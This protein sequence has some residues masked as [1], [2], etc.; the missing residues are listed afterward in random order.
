MKK[1]FFRLRYFLSHR[2]KRDHFILAFETDNILF[3]KNET[4]QYLTFENMQRLGYDASQPVA[5]NNNLLNQA[6]VIKTILV[7]PL[8]KNIWRS[9][10]FTVVCSHAL[11]EDAVLHM[12]RLCE[13]LGGTNITVSSVRST[14]E[15]LSRP[16]YRLIRENYLINA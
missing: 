5:K 1:I 11:E 6:S 2:W 15:F 13:L 10:S 16:H 12:H 7:T 4:S 3:I 8:R 9:P 14:K